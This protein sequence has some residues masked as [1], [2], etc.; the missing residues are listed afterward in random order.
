MKRILIAFAILDAVLTLVALAAAAGYIIGRSS[1]L[2]EADL[3]HRAE[4]VE[5]R[6]QS[7][8]DGY[9]ASEIDRSVLR[10]QEPIPEGE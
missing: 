1:G 2:V 4:M 9:N 5:A 3:V 8:Q 7:F 10:N 6:E